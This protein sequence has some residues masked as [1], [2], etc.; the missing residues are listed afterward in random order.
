MLE[1][2]TKA[3]MRVAEEMCRCSTR[4]EA[5]ERLCMSDES[6]KLHRKRIYSKLNVR[7]EAELVVLAIC[8]RLGKSFDVKKLRESGVSALLGVWL[9][10]LSVAGNA[11]DDM[12]QARRM[13]RGREDVELIMSDG[14]EEEE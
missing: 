2:L 1:V 12:R 7:N 13:R 5:A 11:P 6:V 10:V 3:E 8:E 14:D 9:L 4:R